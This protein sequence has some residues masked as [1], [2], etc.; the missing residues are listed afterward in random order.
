LKPAKSLRIIVS[1]TN[2]LSTDQRVLKVCQTLSEVGYLVLLVGRKR[3][4]SLAIPSHIP[5]KTKRLKLWFDS[6]FLFYAEFNIRLFF[7]LLFKKMDVL[8]AND[9]DALLP[10]FLISKFKNKKLIYDSHEYFTGVPE[11][12]NR[13]IVKKVW[14]NIE[15]FIF[16][17]LNHVFTVN[18]SIADL[19]YGDYK[20]KPIVIRNVPQ[21]KNLNIS[22]Q[23]INLSKDRFTIILQGNGINVDRGAEE[24]VSAMRF[25]ENA[26][27]YIIGNGDAIPEINRLVNQFH[28]SD[29]IKILPSMPY[30]E[31]MQYT[32]SAD[33]GLSLDKDNN[34]NYKFSLP[35]KIFDY[36]RAGIPFLASDLIEIRK[37]A[38]ETQAGV[39]ISEV[40]PENIST[41]I[42]QLIQNPS[43]YALLKQNARS[44][45]ERYN[46][47]N[48]V[49]PMLQAYNSLFAS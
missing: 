5:F 15:K 14:K 18:E 41:A 47:E 37:I 12:Q 24:A 48:E 40:N 17:K 38:E 22:E 49:K 26:I 39:L 45:S 27:F 33:L 8:H 6:G 35:N 28:L 25:I 1:V 32:L 34:I 11:I 2:D 7:F 43:M 29:K 46:W 3:K 10:N 21:R 42:N 44:N 19:Y 20:L 16:P 9:L 36:L 13:P 31:L 30:A 4:N 23:Q